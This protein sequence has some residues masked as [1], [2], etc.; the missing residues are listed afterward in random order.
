MKIK[1]YIT[2]AFL[3]MQVF[4]Y[5]GEYDEAKLKAHWESN[6]ADEIEGIYSVKQTQSLNGDVRSFIYR[7]NFFILKKSN[8][9]IIGEVGGKIM[10]TLVSNYLMEQF[11]LEF[12]IANWCCPDDPQISR[13][14]LKKWSDTEIKSELIKVI[15]GGEQPYFFKIELTL[16]YKPQIKEDIQENISGTGF[17]ISNDGIVVTNFHV[18]SS[19]KSIKIKGINSNFSIAYNATV[20]VF[21]DPKNDLVLLIN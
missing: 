13:V 5:G 16:V 18:V 3:F 20:L 19:A 14:Y 2:L 17:A 8:M 9:Y 6:K 10:G 21:S 15:L 7:N 12:D 4:T 1:E 11:T